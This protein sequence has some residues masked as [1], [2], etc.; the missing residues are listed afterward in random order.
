MFP[1]F[2][3]HK[4]VILIKPNI[5]L[6]LISFL[7]EHPNCFLFLF[8]SCSFLGIPAPLIINSL[9]VAGFDLLNTLPFRISDP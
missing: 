3:E 9:I 2:L 8:F 4:S 7:F 6:F 1:F 5:I